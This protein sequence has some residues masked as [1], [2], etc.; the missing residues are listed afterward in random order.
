MIGLYLMHKRRLVHRLD[1]PA[2]LTFF[3]TKRCNL[4]CSHCFYWKSLNKDND[5][6]LSLG[7]IEKILPS[8]KR[9]VSLALTGG[10]PFLRKDLCDICDLFSRYKK[11]SEIGI[12]TNGY[13][14]DDIVS[15]TE[16]I[17]NKTSIPLSVQISLDGREETHDQIRGLKGS[18]KN[19]IETLRKLNRIRN[20]HA[21][22][23]KTAVAFAI[24]KENLKEVERFIDFIA[25]FRVP[26]RFLI[27]RGE[28][29]GLYNLPKEASSHIN[30]RS[31][32]SADLCVSE[33]EDIF[34]AIDQKNINS[35]YKFWCL[36]Q[37]RITGLSLET[38][39]CENRKL[40]CYAGTMEG[41]IYSNGEVAFCEFMKTIGSL[42][43]VDYDF[44]KLWR[45]DRANEMRRLVKRCSC[46]HSCAIG[47]SLLLH[48]RQIVNEA[49]LTS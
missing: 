38:M 24:Q 26:V 42:K 8:L 35:P 39:R 2:A 12:A 5:Q 20:N 11:V 41:V 6:E 40:P 19:A 16:R 15:Q 14:T 13:D 17:I 48:E 46:I 28:N 10:E 32:H 7:E 1:A 29:F 47:T 34:H 27:T 9:R 4:K 21:G 23:F 37:K 36:K 30:P 31:E 18:F 33:L 49:I 25:P 45:S 3:V 44:S 22:S 43:T